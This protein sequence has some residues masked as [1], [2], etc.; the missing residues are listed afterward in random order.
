MGG[1]RREIE[2]ALKQPLARARD[3]RGDAQREV[4]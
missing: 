2:R 3:Y 4:I 1:Q